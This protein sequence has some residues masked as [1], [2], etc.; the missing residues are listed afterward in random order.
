MPFRLR[1]F[2]R[3]LEHIARH[4]DRVWIASA[5]AIAQHYIDVVPGP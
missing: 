1:H 5:G 2:R 3:A 4:R